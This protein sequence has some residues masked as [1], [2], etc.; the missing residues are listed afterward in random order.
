MLPKSPSNLN[1]VTNNKAR[2]L[3]DAGYS[4]NQQQNLQLSKFNRNIIKQPQSQ[5]NK[6]SSNLNTETNSYYTKSDLKQHKSSF[7]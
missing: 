1:T 4:S 6:Y 5:L 3:I 7:F 2:K